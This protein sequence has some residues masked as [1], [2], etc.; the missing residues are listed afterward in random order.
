VGVTVHRRER[1]HSTGPNQ[2]WSMDFVADQLANGRKFRLLTKVDIFTREFLAIESEQKLKGEDVV[3]A[4]NRI[5]I[6]RGVPKF[7]YCDTGSESSSQARI[8]G[9]IRTECVWRFP[10]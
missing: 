1:F 10:N 3:L 7:H 9:H 5:K 8:Y 6:H 2:E 4:L